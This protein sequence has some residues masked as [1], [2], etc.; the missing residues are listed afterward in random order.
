MKHFK[1]LVF[2]LLAIVLNSCS[3]SEEGETNTG[4]IQPITSIVISADELV[5]PIGEIVT[6]TVKD[7]NGTDVTN[8][9]NIFVDG[10]EITG[11]TITSDQSKTFRVQAKYEGI[12]SNLINVIFNQASSP[13]QPKSFVKRV[14]IEDY[15]GAWCGWCPRVSRAI[16][17]VYEQTDKVVV[18]ALH[19]G[20]LNP[21]SAYYDPYH[22][23]VDQLANLVGV[24]GYPTA[25]L[26]RMTTWSNPEPQRVSQITNKIT[27]D[28]PK[29]GLAL[30]VNIN[31]GNIELDV[32]TTFTRDY[33]NL[34]LVVY[35]LE[36]GLILDQVNY[37]NYYGGQDNIIDF[38]HNHVYRASLTE[39]LGQELLNSETKRDGITTTTFNTPIPSNVTNVNNMEIVAFVIGQDNRAINARKATPGDDQDFEIIE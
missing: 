31:N 12:N 14:L 19:N 6:L 21:N 27:N 3:P 34:K 16:E 17:L 1:I 39:L 28:N 36:N 22:M 18:A 11:N 15:T 29:L 7:N 8:N 30:K 23:N 9:S 25:K 4:G 24:T 2:T 20:S 38:V 37:T 35:V 5:K 32:K 10:E 26:D 33:S 13:A